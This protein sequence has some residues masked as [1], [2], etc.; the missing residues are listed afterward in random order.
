MLTLRDPIRL[1]TAGLVLKG[2]G[3]SFGERV[4]GNYGLICA[5][6]TPKELILLFTAPQEALEG[7]GGITTVAVQNNNFDLR[8]TAV[9]V[10]NRVLNRVLLSGGIRLTYQDSVYI[11]T[12]LEKLG[13]ADAPEFMRQTRLSMAGETNIRRLTALYENNLTLIRSIAG[14][15]ERGGGFAAEKGEQQQEKPPQRARR[16]L[17]NS[18]YSRLQT[19]KLYREVNA[20]QQS[21]T[22]VSLGFYR[23]QFSTAEQLHVSSLLRLSQV[24]NQTDFGGDFILNQSGNY[25]E[26]GFSA[27]SPQSERRIL[28][29]LAAAVLLNAVQRAAALAVN[30]RLNNTWLDFSEVIGRAADNTLVRCQFLYN[31]P[32]AAEN[33]YYSAE[34]NESRN[35]LYSEEYSLLSRLIAQSRAENSCYSG[36]GAFYNAQTSAI[37]Y[38]SRGGDTGAAESGRTAGSETQGKPPPTAQI[39]QMTERLLAEQAPAPP[40]VLP[41]ARVTAG[42]TRVLHTMQSA[43]RESHTRRELLSQRLALVIRAERL[44]EEPP[45]RDEAAAVPSENQ[46]I[47][48][49]AEHR[50]DGTNSL[51]SRILQG[52][53]GRGDRTFTENTRE[54]KTDSLHSHS[55]REQSQTER[56]TERENSTILRERLDRADEHNREMLRQVSESKT[57]R[58]YLPPPLK[59]DQR[60]VMAD[61]LRALDAPELILREVMERREVK[62]IRPKLSPR[63]ELLLAHADAP[64]RKA[65]EAVLLKERGAGQGENAGLKPQIITALNAQTA[66]AGKSPGVTAAERESLERFKEA[67][68]AR[69]FAGRSAAVPSAEAAAPAAEQLRPSR[70]PLSFTYRRERQS[71]SENITNKLET[72]QITTEQSTQN[73][74]N[75]RDTVRLAELEEINRQTVRRTTEDI[76][77]QINRQLVGQLGALS[78]KVYSQIEKRLRME[79]ARR[80]I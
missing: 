74:I 60:R 75:H 77:E 12:A 57:E 63:E 56:F 69:R 39:N 38:A 68:H 45:E 72:R 47:F 40:P 41:P 23:A 29:G 22:P 2:G 13:I 3:A 26:R 35:S 18:V 78:D 19:S 7:F 15:A 34:Q 61:A 4:R 54:L 1:K 28:G 62:P 71:P 24:K 6:F 42:D 32:E 51:L 46:P 20:F 44:M 31:A 43:L 64:E 58:V 17:H 21:F 66:L 59:A 70:P 67:E 14:K 11:S 79:R 73:Q 33:Y 16:F 49:R 37:S 53:A 9:Q 55:A 27:Q 65:L 36:R 48:E 52:A 5:S 10:L 50:H 30:N 80:G 25:Y 76:S 8:Q